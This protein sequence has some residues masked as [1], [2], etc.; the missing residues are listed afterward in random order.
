MHLLHTKLIYR[1]VTISYILAII[2]LNQESMDLIT[3]WLKNYEMECTLFK[4]IIYQDIGSKFLLKDY[5]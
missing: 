5:Q 3:D 1:F 4:M 2:T